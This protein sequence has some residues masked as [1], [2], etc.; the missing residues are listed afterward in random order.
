MFLNFRGN[1]E[2]DEIIRTL[3]KENKQLRIELEAYRTQVEAISD[4]KK[5]YES[6]TDGIKELRQRYEDKLHK[7][8]DL[9]LQY[10]QQLKDVINNVGKGG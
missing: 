2:K 4:L 9:T 1:N 5:E 10:E 6:L 8:D 7:L 3:A